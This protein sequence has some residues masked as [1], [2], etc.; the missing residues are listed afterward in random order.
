VNR[1]NKKADWNGQDWYVAF[2]ED[3]GHRAW[4]DASKYGFVSAGGGPW[5]SR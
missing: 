5:F 4:E 2:G 3:S 1:S